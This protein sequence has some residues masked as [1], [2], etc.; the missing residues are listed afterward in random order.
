M[1]SKCWSA[2]FPRATNPLEIAQTEMPSS[3]NFSAPDNL[4]KIISNKG[5]PETQKEKKREKDALQSVGEDND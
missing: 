1:V 3:I 5:K 4:F 2:N